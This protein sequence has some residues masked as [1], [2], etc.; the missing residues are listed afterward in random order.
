MTRHNL[1]LQLA[2]LLG[3]THNVPTPPVILP[4]ANVSVT[5]GAEP[6]SLSQFQSQIAVEFLPAG[7]TRL[8]VNGQELGSDEFARPLLPASANQ[9][10]SSDEMVQLQSAAK[11]N[12]KPRLLSQ[13]LPELASTPKQHSTL[14]TGTSL[15]DQYNAAYS[16]ENIGPMNKKRTGH[17]VQQL[18]TPVTASSNRFASRN[19]KL[20][21]DLTKDPEPYTSSSSTFETFGE[22]RALWREDSATRKEPLPRKGKKR[23]SDDLDFDDELGNNAPRTFSQSSFTAI[24]SFLEDARPIDRKESH[25]QSSK[26][27]RSPIK[28]TQR[29]QLKLE[30]S[31]SNDCGL[32]GIPKHS[33][34]QPEPKGSAIGD[35]QEVA[36]D[37][38]LAHKYPKKAVADSEDEY[39]DLEMLDR[40]EADGTDAKSTSWRNPVS[41]RSDSNPKHGSPD[42]LEPVPSLDSNTIPAAA[43]QVAQPS[44]GASP[45]QRDS[46]T[47]LNLANPAQS[48]AGS[49]TNAN[50]TLS[51][52]EDVRVQQFMGIQLH[53]IQ[54]YLNELLRAQRSTCQAIY[55]WQMA[56]NQPDPDL[57]AKISSI[58]MEIKTLEP[59]AQLRDRHFQLTQRH[60]VVKAEIFDA[61]RRDQPIVS[62]IEE[63]Q[64]LLEKLNQ[65]KQSVSLLL[66]QNPFEMP[67]YCLSSPRTVSRQ[68]LGSNPRESTT[69]TVVKSTQEPQL[70]LNVK[71]QVVSPKLPSTAQYFQQTQIKVLSRT[72][73]PPISNIDTRTLNKSPLRTY[74]SSPVAKNVNAY[75]SPS[76]KLAWKMSAAPDPPLH[77]IPNP[78][79][80]ELGGYPRTKDTMTEPFD[81]DDDDLFSNHMGSPTKQADPTGFDYDDDYFGEEEDDE[82]LYDEVAKQYDPRAT[83]PHPNAGFEHRVV[84]AETT[85]NIV[86]KQDS[87]FP[88]ERSGAVSQHAQ[89]QY[90][91][92]SEVKAAMRERFHL[93]GFRH[94]QLE[95]INATLDGKDAFV[96]MPTGGGKSLCYQLPSIIKS[97]NTQGVSVV[98]S[99]LLS[100]M[101]DQVDHL[102]NL[103]IQALLINGEVTLDHRRVVLN[104]L[105]GP[106]P[107]KFI[108]LLYVTPE[109]INNSQALT[110]ALQDLHH[111]RRLARIVID[112][113]HCVSQWGHDFR[114]DYKSLG[115][116]R[117][118]FDGVPVMA[119]TATATE[120]VKTDVIHNLGIKGCKIFTQSFNRPNLTYK[121]FP[122]G[123]AKNAIE[124]MAKIINS[125]YRNQTGI[126]YCLSRKNCETV[127][128]QLRAAHNIKA[129]YYHAGMKPEEKANAQKAWQAGKYHVI[130]ATIAFGMGIDKPDVR[131]VIHLT[132]PKSLEGYYQETGRAGR[133]GKLS[134]CYLYY[135]YQDTSALKRMIDDGEGSWEQKE[136][137][138]Q[139]LRSV[140]QFCENRSDCRRVQIL[141][142]FNESFRSQDCH[143][144]C[145]NCS[146][147]TTFETQDFTEFAALAISL[148]GKVQ[149]DNVT[150]LHCVDI[151]RGS[152]SKKIC[153]MG[154]HRLEEFGAGSDLERGNVERLFYRLLSEDAFKE[155]HEVN[156]AG[157]ALQYVGVRSPILRVL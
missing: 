70:P 94:N 24:E 98:I 144:S 156:K 118:Q 99:P 11:S 127:S 85:G 28:P 152:K 114:P 2:W 108:Q 109:M 105:S 33:A 36:N 112:E 63:N 30:S 136:R 128:Q 15:G 90:R 138:R 4:P 104:K 54:S 142:Y 50:D 52:E 16:R 46:P 146:S 74:T 35:N 55:D 66:N 6:Y 81:E 43:I 26:Q 96:L 110:R 73:P 39:E 76:K 21:V 103:K 124:D 155:K 116:L 119:L 41:G 42:P 91:W 80:P 29:R 5:L 145:D 132:I 129:H 139:M 71:S 9:P 45:F 88:P 56:G 87:N 150:L 122:K 23:K 1:Q 12:M 123:N 75:F 62:A 133:D 19:D 83:E 53:Q 68:Q 25:D 57:Q 18:H 135:G 125:H 157:F 37:K 115:E 31:M 120:N 14:K 107:E 47:K 69:A 102:Q 40:P 61:L 79:V 134:G 8:D 153:D 93:K 111:R 51:A 48:V 58:N 44:V 59:L 117:R 97:G 65:I 22:S 149:G 7:I 34:K 60:D 49:N 72:T 67:Q 148:V 121:V 137:Q 106:D 95:A 89:M 3:S 143:A 78:P 131:F 86:R 126:I 84:L 130:V 100:L 82:G 77:S 10:S 140:I 92:S 147:N 32:M 151:F 20:P 154:H 113:A 141:H 38:I 101:Q 27:K 13:A 64:E 17:E